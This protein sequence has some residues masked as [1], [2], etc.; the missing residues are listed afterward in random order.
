MAYKIFTIESG[1]IKEGAKVEKFV[2]KNANLSIPAIIVGETGRGRRLGVLPVQLSEELRKKWEEGEVGIFTAEVGQTR[3]GNPKLITASSKS[4]SNEK[5]ICVFR[6]KIGFRGG[7]D[8][9]GDLAEEWWEFDKFYSE[10]AKNCGIPMKE[11]YTREETQ[12][13]SAQLMKYRHGTTQGYR[14]DAGFYHYK[15]YLPFPGNILVKGIIAQGAAG[16]MGSGEQLI[17]IVPKNIVV[18]TAYSG[19]LYG[20]PEEH[21]YLWNGEQLLS[22]SGEERTIT[23]IF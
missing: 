5:V 2:L 8:H 4:V 7:N 16:K 14:W 21:Y 13:Y 17:A 11:R 6:T 3:N 1:S 9:T 19:R 10:D 18:R 22:I 20:A 12:Q 15:K 23:E